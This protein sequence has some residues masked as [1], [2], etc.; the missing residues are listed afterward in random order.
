MSRL[1]K[2]CAALLLMSGLLFGGFPRPDLLLPR[3]DVCT[4]Q[5]GW[6]GNG[7]DD[8][9]AHQGAKISRAGLSDN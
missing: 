5:G 7:A 4:S 2:R 8:T 1:N 9:R 6:L 3:L